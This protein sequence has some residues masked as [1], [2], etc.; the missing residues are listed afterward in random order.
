MPPSTH[1]TYYQFT[2]VE[3]ARKRY[4]GD[5]NRRHALLAAVTYLALKYVSRI[6]MH[7]LQAML[8]LPNFDHRHHFIQ[9]VLHTGQLWQ[10]HAQVFLYPHLSVI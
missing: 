1:Y 4:K 9:S 5:N 3:H 8:D 7:T 10:D 6:R 2:H